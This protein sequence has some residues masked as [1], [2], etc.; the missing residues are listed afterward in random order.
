MRV[1][2][3][4]AGVAGP[5]LA[6]WLSRA[7]HSVTI[8]EQAPA[9]RTG[10]Y[11]IDFWGTGYEIATR[12][13]LISRIRALGYQVRE[14][15]LVNRSGRK[16]GGFM[17]DVFS[18]VTGDRFTSVGRSALSAT[19]MGALGDRV[20]TIFGDSVA[21]IEDSGGCVHV[22]LENGGERE[23]DL[24]VGAVGLHSRVRAL[25]FG[26]EADF[27]VPL[28]YHVAAFEL[29]GYRPRDELVY[30]TY[31]VAGRQISR[32]SMRDDRTLVLCVF[33]DEYL[34]RGRPVTDAERRAALHEIFDGLGWECDRILPALDGAPEL[35]FD[36]VSQIRM[37][38]WSRGRVA[39]VGDAAAC[40]SLLAGE[41]T[42]LAM[43]EAYVLAAML[44]TASDHAAAFAEYERRMMPFLAGKQRAAAGFAASFAPRTTLGLHVRN[45]VTRL[46]GIPAVAEWAV[47]R[48]LR[49][50]IDLPPTPVGTAGN[51]SARAG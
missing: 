38:S 44:E 25:T 36:R 6:W 2:I 18:R 4:G 17:V 40:V 49:D 43:T 5:T 33:R 9:L 30:I 13:G 26:A 19:I 7:G 31:G 16:V 35:Y 47:G 45:L 14:V 20:E 15:R 22:R 29:E 37:P 48:S 23:L 1:L 21:A 12:M 32:F 34:T 28:G 41:G 24:V 27:E 50:D 8:V 3:S 11:V 10:G 51:S 39:L 42:G 46:F